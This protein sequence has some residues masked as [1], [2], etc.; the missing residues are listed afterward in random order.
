[1]NAS[2]SRIWRSYLASIQQLPD[3]AP[4]PPAWHFCDNEDDA[5]ECLRLVLSGEKRATAPSVWELEAAG[6][7]L[8]EV[9]DL[10]IITDWN[11]EARCIIRTTEVTILPFASVSAEHARLEGEGDGSLAY[12]REVHRAYYGRVLTGTNRAFDPQMPVVFE[13]FEVVFTL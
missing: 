3:D 2:I 6:D 7:P 10:N 4:A 13:Q 8:P 12:W 9:G 11:G 1:M 5:N